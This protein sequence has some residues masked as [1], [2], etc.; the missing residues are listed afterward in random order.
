MRVRPCGEMEFTV[1]PYFAMRERR[2]AREPDDAFLRR[3]V[4][5]LTRAALEPRRRRE[6]DDAARAL[7][8]HVARGRLHHGEVALEVHRHHRVPLLLAHV[9]DH[10]L[11]QNARAADD[12]VEIAVG[13]ERGRS[14][15][16]RPPAM[17]ATLSA[18]ATACPPRLSISFTTA[19]AAALEGSRP[20]TLTP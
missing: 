18:L 2:R 1:T 3:R 15:T 12:D 20:S 13:R 8:A 11:P 4:V 10:P 14:T 5:G 7:L 17:V 16:A 9:E 19:F 6:G